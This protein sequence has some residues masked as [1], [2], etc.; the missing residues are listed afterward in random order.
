[1]SPP[2]ARLEKFQ[3][4]ILVDPSLDQS[5]W[6]RGWCPVM[7]DPSTSTRM[8]REGSSSLKGEKVVLVQQAPQMGSGGNRA[9]AQVSTSEAGTSVTKQHNSQITDKVSILP[10]E[11]K[12]P[13][14]W[15]TPLLK[16][17]V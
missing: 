8:E 3:E 7:G 5:L 2:R 14:Q 13:T 4:R 9:F 10:A 12:P 6:L 11:H 15:L 16:R 1:M 17:M